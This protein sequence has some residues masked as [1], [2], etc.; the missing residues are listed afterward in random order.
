ML[1]SPAPSVANDRRVAQV[2]PWLTVR[3]KTALIRPDAEI[4]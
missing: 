1:N 3:R 2:T 4:V